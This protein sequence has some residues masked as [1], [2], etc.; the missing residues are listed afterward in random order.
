MTT[1]TALLV[2]LAIALGAAPA[3]AGEYIYPDGAGNLVVRDVGGPKRILVGRGPTAEET[4]R[5]FEDGWDARYDGAFLP[6]R[7]RVYDDGKG[8]LTYSG[9][10]GAK[11]IVV[12]RNS[13][14]VTAPL[15]AVPEA[16]ASVIY[17]CPPELTRS[18][19][20]NGRTALSRCD[21]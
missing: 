15:L 3:T 16:T 14:V 12:A 21:R 8:N 9:R 4:I 6:G 1:K 10:H 17:Y 20:G 5:I 13:D 7:Q 18:G 2:G 19:K 11:R